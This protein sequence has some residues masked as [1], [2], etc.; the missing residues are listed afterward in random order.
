MRISIFLVMS[1]L[2]AYNSHAQNKNAVLKLIERVL[3]NH[4]KQIE[5]HYSKENTEK[6]WYEIETKKNKVII[7]ATNNVSIAA[8]LH[9]YLKNYTNSS[10]SWTG[11]QEPKALS[12]LSKKVENTV[13]S[14]YRLY[15]NYC[16]FNYTMSFWNWER[17]EKEIDW[18]ALR[19]INM[20]LAMVGQE[21]VWQN[22]LRRLGYTDSEIKDFI[23]G[24]AFNAWWLMGNLEGWGGPVPQSWIDEQAEL[25]KKIVNRM[26]DL[27]MKPIMQGFYGM[28]PNS[29]I[30]NI[31]QLKYTILVYGVVLSVLR[32]CYQQIHFL[33]KFQ[34]FIM[35]NKK[36]FMEEQIITKEIHS[37]KEEHL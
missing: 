15:F 8:A 13:I 20:P 28:V 22:T 7:K 19:G 18:M 14:D 25:Q 37:M 24:P 30:K 29:L 3:P 1:I 33:V 36:S 23:G 35:K 9:Y 17:W 32:C 12:K 11:Y 26:R 2:C 34:K 10:L 31:H 6:D 4:H 16:T 5:V 27:G 21:A